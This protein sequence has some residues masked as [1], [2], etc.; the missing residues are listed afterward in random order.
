MIAQDTC[1]SVWLEGVFLRILELFQ[2]EWRGKSQHKG[3]LGASRLRDCDRKRTQVS[4]ASRWIREYIPNKMNLNIIFQSG[5]Y[6]RIPMRI[7]RIL[8]ETDR[9]GRA[10]GVDWEGE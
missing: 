6:D 2:E 9:S 1:L 3:M 10:G 5:C 7:L 8:V 4:E